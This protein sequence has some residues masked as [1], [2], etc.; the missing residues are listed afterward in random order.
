MQD[1]TFVFLK[2]DL[3]QPDYEVVPIENYEGFSKGPMNLVLA[4]NKQSGEKYLLA[5]AHGNS[6][7]AEDGRLQIT[8]IKEKFESLSQQ[9]A[10]LQLLIGIDANTKKRRTLKL[11]REHM[12]LLGLIAAEVWTHHH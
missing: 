5:S 3:W 9:I 6:T 1:G 2:S 12:D 7:K 11:L 8:L 10:G 4:T